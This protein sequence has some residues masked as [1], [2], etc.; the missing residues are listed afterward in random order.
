MMKVDVLTESFASLRGDILILP[1]FQSEKLSKGGPGEAEFLPN[2]LVSFVD[3]K[4]IEGGDFRGK[5]GEFLWF[6]PLARVGLARAG[7]AQSEDGNR[8]PR[9]D[10]AGGVERIGLLGLGEKEKFTQQ[11]LREA[12][13]TVARQIQKARLSGMLFWARELGN[14]SPLDPRYAQ[15]VIEGA[16]LA[17]YQ[18]RE[19]KTNGEPGEEKSLEHLGF[20]IPAG[21]QERSPSVAGR[22]LSE[23]ARVGEILADAVQFVRDLGNYPP[24]RVTPAFLAERAYE[25]AKD[26][27]L[28]CQV[29]TE[30]EMHQL[31]MG[32][33]LGV[34]QGSNN[35]PRFIILEY[36]PDSEKPVQSEEETIVVIGKGVTFDSGGISLKSA[37]GMEEMKFDMAGGA[38]VFGVLQAAARLKLPLHIVGLV[39][40]VENLPGGRAYRPGDILTS[41]SGKTIEII[42]TDAEGRLILADAL[43]YARR[44]QPQAVVDLATLTG[45]CV[46]ALGHLASGLLGND[47]SLIKRIKQAAEASG[48]R[49][50]E[51]P[52]WE[53]YHDSLKSEVA[54]LKNV[55]GRAAGVIT[56]AAFLAK[57]A[58]GYPW[59]H[60]D[61]AGTA[62]TDKETP[63]GPKGATG[64]GVRLLVEM[65]RQWKTSIP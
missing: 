19:Y 38:T 28:R 8:E 50:W 11:V 62:W 48:E 40:A 41:M 59:A 17:T 44:Y 52:L 18:F 22:A 6:Y 42:T 30:E 10:L 63:L 25:L 47:P 1:L 33:L 39:P 23:G 12:V 26:L 14:L 60:L 31:R 4:I 24:N 35:P 32:A 64:V 54:D 21:K 27:G 46:I 58:E 2:S 55:G 34:A 43:T 13:G 53:E 20:W 36:K 7:L 61:I 37:K 16:R 49:V 3:G 45:A 5:K 29:L 15:V 56:A 9:S 65:L 57:F 51:L